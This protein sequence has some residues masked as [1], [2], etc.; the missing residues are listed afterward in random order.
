VDTLAHVPF[1]VGS[2]WT[3]RWGWIGS[4]ALAF[5]I[6]VGLSPAPAFAG[7]VT[8]TRKAKHS[9]AHRAT[10]DLKS[11]QKSK[12]GREI[13]WR[14]SNNRCDVVSSDGINHG[15]WQ[16]TLQLWRSYGGPK[17]AKTPERATCLEQDRVARRVWI[18]Q[19]WGPWGG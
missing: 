9:Q 1:S 18:D 6:T 19:W 16:M 10:I 13:S 17:F 14:E 2:T 5:V 15:K 7:D 3:R 12:H 4:V 11:W 8:M